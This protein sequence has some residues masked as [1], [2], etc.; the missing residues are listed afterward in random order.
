MR[1][2]LMTPALIALALLPC[3]TVGALPAGRGMARRGA[4]PLFVQAAAASVVSG[5]HVSAAL[6][7][8][9]GGTLV[10]YA[11]WDNP[12]TA[13]LTDNRGGA[14]LP[15]SPA[16]LWHA[17]QWSA[18]L[19]TATAADGAT[20]ITA[21]FGTAIQ[22]F[23][24]LY[25][26]EYAGAAS[27]DAAAGQSGASGSLASGTLAT[28]ASGD[29]LVAAGAS[30][31]TVTAASSGYTSRST[32]FGNMIEDRLATA[33]GPYSAA[34]SQNGQAWVLQL[35]ALRPAGSPAPTAT[36]TSTSSPPPATATAT[37]TIT[38]TA[39][40]TS[41]PIPDAAPSFPL[42]ASANKRSLIGSN[43]VPFLLMGD[44][45]HSLVVNLTPA[46]MDQ[47][48]ADRQAHGFNAAWVEV[49][50][51]TYTGG[52]ADGSTYDGILPF[53]SPGDLST[54]NPAYFARLDYAVQSAAGHGIA[55]FLTPLD[56]GGWLGTLQANGLTKD[57]AYGA[58]LG[59]RYKGYANI[60]WQL[61]NDFQTWR[62]PSD[63]ALVRGIATG[64]AS[65]DPTH[66][67]TSELDY[68]VSDTLQDPTW[69]ALA[70]LDSVYTYFPTYAQMLAAYNRTA[71]PTYLVEAHYEGENV[72]FDLG[73]P[74]VV[75]KQGYWTMLSG[76]TGQL[77]GSQYWNFAS[78]WQAGIDSIGVTHLGYWK[79]L[80]G[81][82][83]WYNL[84]PDQ[85][86]T[87][88]TGGLGTFSA[89]GTLSGNDYLT[90]ARTSDGTLALAYL[91]SQR[92]IAVNMAQMAA[93]ALARWYDPT[94]GQYQM[95]ASN[96]HIP[97]YQANAGTAQ[98]TPPGPNS[99]GD[100]DWVLV[101]ETQ[102]SSATFTATVT[103][104]SATATSIAT[105]TATPPICT[106]ETIRR[107]PHG[108]VLSDVT[109]PYAC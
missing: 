12:G 61:G 19:Y 15:A 64:I 81:S 32:A 18:Q 98:F 53:T 35:V 71:A 42:A 6:A 45:P 50:D 14:Y 68:Y 75:R 85:G 60:V 3:L 11:V 106:E 70:G 33:P 83:Q 66:L 56:Q 99:A 54:P 43:G 63:D 30:D 95:D 9:A 82:R 29:L 90:A 73:T 38:A 24:L 55:L 20:T 16:L 108:V 96:G 97:G 92:T 34:A 77:Y 36:P 10:A 41:T 22:S 87:L 48:F 86:H 13:T 46:Q 94:S 49:L 67:V 69:A 47:Y 31:N 100:G 88:V 102:G 105:A 101:L 79:L 4:V 107:D 93:P 27:P 84:V 17:G 72:G 103:V 7:T 52:R 80:F 25:V 51:K 89:A 39:T 21:T 44:A 28:T 65:V 26:A 62:T 74:L 40:E 23:G 91:P 76:G 78:G 59:S 5:T 109:V 2:P 37:I 8:V 1:R 58:F 57:T 104:A